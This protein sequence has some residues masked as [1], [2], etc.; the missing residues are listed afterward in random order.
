MVSGA[1]TG[2]G[3][4]PADDYDDEEEY[5]PVT[6]L[7]DDYIAYLTAKVQEYE[8]Q[9]QA[10][11][12]YHGAQW[13][14]EEIKVLRR[15]RQPII[16]YNRVG[17][18]IDQVVGLIKR[19]RQDPKAF[20]RNPKNADGAEIATQCVRAVLD[21]ADWEFIDPFCA[22]QAAIEGIGGIELKLIPGDHDD[23]DLGMDFVFGDDWFYDPRSF[24]PDFSDARFYGIGK[25]LDLDAAI[26]LFPD[27][28]EELRTLMVETGF[29]LTTH[30]DREYK[31]IYVNEKRLRLVEMWYINKGKWY[32]CFFCSMLKLDEGP[33][34]FRDERNRSTSRFIMFSANVDHDG[35]RYG[36][37]RNLKGAQDELNQRRSKALHMSNVTAMVG[38]KGA[39]DDV[40]IA[41]REAARPDGYM[42]YNPGFDPPQP[43]DNK[44]DLSAQLSLM[45]DARSEI[46]SFA[47]I[48]PDLIT[49]DVPGD[50]SGVA[51]NLLQR[52][53]IAE[54][55]SYLR[56]YKAWKK[57]VYRGVWNIVQREWQE[58]RFIRVTDSEGLATFITINGTGEDQYGQP[59]IINAI[60]NLSVEMMMDEGPDEANLMQ[61][62]YDVLK[63]YPQGT[64]PPQVL[65]E[66]SP[67][68]AKMKNRVLQ[69]MQ[70]PPNPMQQ[71][72]A[73]LELRNKEAEA[74]NK[75]AQAQERRTR[76]VTDAARAAHLAHE[77][78]MDIAEFVRDAFVEQDKSTAVPPD[79]KDQ[80][81]AQQQQ[82]AQQAQQQPLGTPPAAP[83]VV[84]PP[85]TVPP[86]HPILAHARQA[87][88]GFHYVG[89]PRRPGKFLRVHL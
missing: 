29:D 86:N 1:M 44:A 45:Q 15:R 66:L 21:G 54:L 38:Q 77:A 62:A 22:G 8:E 56:N 17:R 78:N 3:V 23:P 80:A 61:D 85:V 5:W 41:R 30:A 84:P 52:A 6:R 31:W 53:G 60:G 51:I 28:E 16:T 64:I 83:G 26:E 12:Y 25:W 65:I 58:E 4:M 37:T 46:D 81:Q 33:S 47:N 57:R 87:R 73:M 10:R 82:A 50:H 2:Q 11:H 68:S 72:A 79:D 59:V 71:Q 63:Q 40:E 32:W 42:E 20:P 75:E 34:P 88:D 27:K 55:G 13:T 9:R 43:R 49:H 69:L 74:A 76:S 35:D 70:Q 36:L 24:K 18:K 67:L 14:H 48:T 7:R 19:I 39:V 89:D